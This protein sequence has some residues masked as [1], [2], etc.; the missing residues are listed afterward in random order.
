MHVAH[1]A[2]RAVAALADFAAVGVEDPVVKVGIRMPRRLDYQH[3]VEADPGMAVGQPADGRRSRDHR[4]AGGV[5]D[6]EVVA[7]AVHLGETDSH[8]ASGVRG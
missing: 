7:R 2:A 3:L 1:E 5:D 4:R 8:E 6:D